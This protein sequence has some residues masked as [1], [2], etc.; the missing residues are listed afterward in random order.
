MGDTIAQN[1]VLD[2]EKTK[3]TQALEITSLKR[4]VKKLKKKQR[5]HKLKRLYKVGLTARVDSSKD[6]QSLEVF[7]EKEVADREVSAASEVNVAT[8]A[9]TVS[10]AATIT[11]EEVTLAQ[12]L[13]KIK[14]TKPKVAVIV[15]QEPTNIDADHQL[16]ERLQAEEQQE[17][18]DEE[19]A[20]LFMQIL[21]KRRKFFVA[22]RA[23]D[24]RNKPPTQ[25][26]QRK[27]TCIYLNNVE[28]KK[29]KDFKNKSFDSIQEMFNGAFKRINTFVN[30]KTELVEGKEEVEIDAIPLAVKSS[31]IIDWKIYKDGKKIYYQIVRADEKSQMYMFFR[32]MLKRFDKEDLEDSSNL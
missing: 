6:E 27:I 4:R 13:I 8:I 16:A 7:V 14:T 31:K 1:R 3:T 17:L 28:G 2:L 23:E 24:K 26:Q 11:T 32:Q 10:A 21:E 30:F 9:I 5:T 29:L 15:L 18:T 25:A 19:K 20:K 12:A 22:K